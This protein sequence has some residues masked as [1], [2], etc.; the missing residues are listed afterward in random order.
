MRQ[1]S[2]ARVVPVPSPPRPPGPSLPFADCHYLLQ[3]IGHLK[4]QRIEQGVSL[5]ALALRARI[6]RS[7]IVHAEQ[8]GNVLNSRDFKAWAAALGLSWDQVWSDCFPE[9]SGSPITHRT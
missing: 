4:Q 2:I 5:H 1:V 3:V 7:E 8:R 9:V 6:K